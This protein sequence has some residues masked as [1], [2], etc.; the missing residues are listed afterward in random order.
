MALILNLEEW[1]DVVRLDFSP[2]A[3]IAPLKVSK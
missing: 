2:Q 1:T 3:K